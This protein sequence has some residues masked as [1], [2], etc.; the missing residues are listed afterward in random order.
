[1]PPETSGWVDHVVTP[2]GAFAFV[3]VE[4]VLDRYLVA[5]VE[6]QTGNRFFRASVRILFNPSRAVE[7]G[8]EPRAVEANGASAVR[9][10]LGV[11]LCAEDADSPSQGSPEIME[12]TTAGLRPFRVT[13]YGVPR[14]IRLNQ[15]GVSACAL[16]SPSVRFA[17]PATK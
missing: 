11:Y 3:V 2:V 14:G 16:P 5:W 13:V 4:D 15:L 12:S 17:S 10:T 8:A 9:V 1:M 7:R 6:R